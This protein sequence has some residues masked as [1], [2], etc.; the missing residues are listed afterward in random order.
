MSS[1]AVL[2][3]FASG[4]FAKASLSAKTSSHV[5]G[6]YQ[7]GRIAPKTDEIIRL[8]P[9]SSFQ[10]VEEALI[11]QPASSKV[12]PAIAMTPMPRFQH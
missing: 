11:T 4:V 6:Y 8:R 5:L 2:T 10:I 12:C 7:V 9:T 3:L 1:D